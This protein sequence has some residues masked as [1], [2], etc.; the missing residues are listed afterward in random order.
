MPL[1]NP[2]A[3]FENDLDLLDFHPDLHLDVKDVKDVK[4]V[5]EVKADEKGETQTSKK[6]S[7]ALYLSFESEQEMLLAWAEFMSA[8]DPDFVTGY[9]ILN[10][11]FPYLLTRAKQLNVHGVFATFGKVTK[12][13]CECRSSIKE[14]QVQGRRDVTEVKV[15]GRVLIDMLPVIRGDT[16]LRSYTLNNVSTTFL[17]GM[18]KEDV[19][20][21][22]ISKLQNG[23]DLQRRKLAK[24]CLRDAELPLLLM[25]KLMSFINL[26]EMARV[27]GVPLNLL[28]QRAQQIRVQSMLLWKSAETYFLVPCFPKK[29]DDLEDEEW[30]GAEVIDP[31]RGFYVDPIATLDFASLYPSIMIAHNLCYSTWIEKKESISKHQLTEDQY[32]IT[33]HGSMFVKENVQPGVLPTILKELLKARS[34]AKSLM[35]DE[36]DPFKKA[37]Y[38]GRQL[39][40]KVSANS[41]YGFTGAQKGV[42][43]LL[44]ISQSVTSYGRTMLDHTKA[45]VEEIYR[46]EN[47]HPFDASVIYGDTD[48]V[49]VKFGDSS[50][51]TCMKKG[52]E[53][54]EII[55]KDFSAPIKL[56]FEKCY[57]PYLLENRK[58]Y[59]GGLW[60]R[61]DKMDK[62]DTK[63]IDTTRREKCMLV[64]NLMQQVLEC[65]LIQRDVEKAKTLVKEVVRDL[66]LGRVDIGQ[67]IMRKSLNKSAEAKDYS[68]KVAHVEM[69]ERMRK[70]DP[71]NAPRLGD[72]V[73]YV[74]V[75]EVSKAK[76]Y[77]YFEDPMYVI[78]NKLPVDYRRYVEKQLRN[79]LTKIFSLLMAPEQTSQLF[80]V[81][82]PY[83]VEIKNQAMLT[84]ASS[85]PS[86]LPLLLK[87][88]QKCY[89]CNF[90]LKKREEKKG[91]CKQ[92]EPQIKK[93]VNALFVGEHTR[94]LSLLSMK[95]NGCQYG[96]LK[97]AVKNKTC[98]GCKCLLAGSASRGLCQVCEK[99]RI[100]I[101]NER[102]QNFENKTEES[103]KMHDICETCQGGTP[104]DDIQCSN[105]ECEHFFKRVKIDEDKSRCKILYDELF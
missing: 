82:P 87:T 60:T 88:S 75:C 97:Y 69:V 42:L 16:K 37:I 71:T 67:L 68:T 79:P 38:N 95:T 53:A 72:A 80:P 27:T 50:L 55:S 101:T 93:K 90:K 77:Q 3:F 13:T 65:I 36:K 43:P 29:D 51:E 105:Y 18:K 32:S 70:R 34:H 52:K 94:K 40:L 5:K 20:H 26:V 81:L 59:S 47:G 25:S 48:S 61:L 85:P 31:K 98:Q 73:F 62:I 56:E 46:I 1:L 2:K 30:I 33:P 15:S 103:K 35:K 104:Y 83:P 4:A 76:S 24:Y 63:G 57:W 7:P 92:C 49:M 8:A 84:S 78:E 9:N 86:R 100:Q 22:A 10:F 58:R 96:I 89:K 23:T 74:Y 6:S 66:F 91:I 99:D 64:K 44:P 12:E 28:L 54:A 102:K 45:R 19:H 21:S 41:V 17:D 11:D 39:A 14:N